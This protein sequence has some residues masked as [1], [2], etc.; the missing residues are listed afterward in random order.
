MN[1]QARHDRS[2]DP[3]NAKEIPLINGCHTWQ[4]R[5]DRITVLRDQ[6]ELSPLSAVA[7]VQRGG[8]P[9]G[10]FYAFDPRRSAILLIGGEKTGDKRF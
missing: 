3:R 6:V 2:H 10:V 8:K 9:L 7:S 1:G 4:C 5:V